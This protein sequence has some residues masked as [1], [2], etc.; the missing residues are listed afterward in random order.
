M[1]F[2]SNSQYSLINYDWRKRK[3]LAVWEGTPRGK[4]L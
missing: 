2:F 1:F 3:L 4:E